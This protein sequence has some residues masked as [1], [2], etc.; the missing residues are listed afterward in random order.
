MKRATAPTARILDLLMSEPAEWKHGYAIMKAAGLGSG[1]LYP[2]LERLRRDGL[3][4]SRTGEDNRTEYQITGLGEK[5]H[6]E[7]KSTKPTWW[8]QVAVVGE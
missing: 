1:T 4:T 5:V 2:S 6:D 3:I 8:F 7:L